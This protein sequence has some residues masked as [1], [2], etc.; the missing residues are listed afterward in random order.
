MVFLIL[1]I[2]Q[3]AY[4]V[5]ISLFITTLYF[6]YLF[7]VHRVYCG[8]FVPWPGIE[9]V[10]LVL[11]AWSLNHWTAR[12]S[13]LNECLDCLQFKASLNIGEGN[14]TH[15]SILAWKIPWTEDPGR[16]Q[17][18]G[19]QKVRHDLATELATF[20]Y[21]SL[22]GHRLYFFWDYAYEWNCWIRRQMC[23]MFY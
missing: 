22:C 9:L 10:L 13:L 6:I 20:L 12:K 1:T 7:W 3:F 15:C 16:L 19:S 5:S 4:P 18:I 11:G 8:I 14:A 21:T 2:R 23:G 17:S